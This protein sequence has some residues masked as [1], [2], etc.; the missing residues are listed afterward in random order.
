MFPSPE[1]NPGPERSENVTA[2][3]EPPSVTMGAGASH[4]I[5]LCAVK[6]PEPEP[7]ALSRKS[8]AVLE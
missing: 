4:T 1:V 3:V 7:G 8:R 6:V 5:K 2:H